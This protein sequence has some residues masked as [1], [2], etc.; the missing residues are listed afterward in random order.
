MTLLALRGTEHWLRQYRYI[1]RG[2]I[3]SSLVTPPIYLAALGYGLGSFVGANPAVTGGVD[4]LAFVGSGLLAAMVL[5]TAA[6]EGTFPVMAAMRWHKQYRAMV[7]APLGPDDVL[8]GHLV[9][10]MLRV[11]MTGLAF[12][13]YLAAFG[14]VRDLAALWVLPVV[15]L[16]GLACMTPLVAFSAYVERDAAIVVLQRFVVTPMM[17]FGGVFFLLDRTPFAVQAIAMATPLWH[18]VELCRDVLLSRPLTGAW[19]HVA[20]LTAWA[21]AGFLAARHVFRT[22]LGS[23]S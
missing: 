3:L 21:A 14:V 18:G 19:L 5:Q 2:T 12:F 7:Y 6:I 17:L 9:F 8:V 15:L 11:L 4:Y 1:W 23:W 22:R 16:V 10:L 13:G 20:V